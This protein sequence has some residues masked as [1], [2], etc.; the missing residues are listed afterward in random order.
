MIKNNI[1]LG[2]F[3][4]IKI[5]EDGNVYTIGSN[6]HGQ[7]G[8][9]KK[10]TRLTPVKVTLPNGE[11]ATSVFANS[12]SS[13]VITDKNNV[14]VWGGNCSGELGIGDKKNK[15]KPQKFTLPNEEIPSVLEI[16]KFHSMCISNKGNLYAWGYNAFGQ[17]GVETPLY[18]LTPILVELPNN[19][20]AIS[21]SLYENSSL[22]VTDKYNIYHWHNERFGNIGIGN[23]NTFYN[24]Q[25]ISLPNEEE[26]SSIKI[27][28]SHCI[29]LS[30][31][32]NIYTCGKNDHGELGL[33]DKVGKSTPQLVNLP[34]NEKAI[35]IFASDFVSMAITEQGNLY[36]WGSNYYGELGLGNTEDQQT[37]QLVNLPDNEKVNSISLGIGSVIATTNKNN[38]YAWGQNSYGQLGTKDTVNHLKPIKI[39]LP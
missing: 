1:G 4:S 18:Q 39:E 25:E 36:S 33:G 2:R 34:N 7:L 26:I 11:K 15:H 19:E 8:R 21:I 32:G 35:S 13:M 14:Y 20:K 38:Y 22:V 5:G 9:V 31:K 16:R 30:N 12:V 37:P 6:F 3:H 23:L 27:G 28:L 24:P 29:F 17:L 10:E